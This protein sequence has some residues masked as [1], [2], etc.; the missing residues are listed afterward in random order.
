MFNGEAWD[1]FISGLKETGKEES[2]PEEE[3]GDAV[4]NP[5]AVPVSPPQEP[6]ISRLPRNRWIAL[7]AAIGIVL[8]G[9][10]SLEGL[11]GSC[12]DAGCLY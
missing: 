8:G 9:G 11:F 1:Q 4:L 12:P 6:K 7:V 2:E 10:R 3:E 5:P